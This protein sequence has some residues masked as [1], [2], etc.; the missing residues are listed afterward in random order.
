MNDCAKLIKIYRREKFSNIVLDLRKFRFVLDG[1]WMTGRRLEN[2]QKMS[3]NYERH[4][5]KTTINLQSKQ[6]KMAK[7][8]EKII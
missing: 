6:N 3:K 5:P 8:Y 4:R 7:F 1:G 2:W